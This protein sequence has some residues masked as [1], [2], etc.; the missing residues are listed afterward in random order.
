MTTTISAQ[1]FIKSNPDGSIAFISKIDNFM[2]SEK[3]FSHE[4]ILF[5]NIM[6]SVIV[7]EIFYRKEISLFE[8][9]VFKQFLKDEAEF[10]VKIEG[11]SSLFYNDFM[12]DNLQ[13]KTETDFDIFVKEIHLEFEKFIKLKSLSELRKVLR[14]LT[15]T[16]SL[17]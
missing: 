14:F 8:K 12:I 16:I 3:E 1:K 11:A 13:S 2:I 10:K 5:Q 9:N 4:E 7:K 17:K 15:Q 6:I